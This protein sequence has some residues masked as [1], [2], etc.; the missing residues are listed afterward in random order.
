MVTHGAAGDTFWDVVKKGA[1]Q[2]GKDEGVKVNYQS[3]GD[4]NKQSQLIDAA[5]NQK[6]DGHRRVDG[7]PGR[8]E[9]L[10]R[11]GRGRGHPR[12]HDQLGPAQSAAFGALAHV[13]QDETIAGQGA[14]EKMKA[15]GV[16]NALCV[17]Q[18]AGNV[19][20]EQRCAG[21]KQTPRR[22]GH[23]R[24]G[25]EQRPGRCAVDHQGQAAV[26]LRRST[27]C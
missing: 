6:V 18:E 13:G 2:A 17:I 16:T 22:Q 14:G 25:A 19:G 1:E 9:G 7:K 23:E 5:V 24:P 20:L 4:P 27:A 11:E 10:H 3:D 26:R 21:F 15:A 12:H 8:A